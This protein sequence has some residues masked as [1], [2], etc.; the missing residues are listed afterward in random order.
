MKQLSDEEL[1]TQSRQSGIAAASDPFLNEL[2]SRHQRRVSLWCLRYAGNRED[3]ADLA[4]EILAR[5]WRNL[6]SYQGN[7]KFTTWL[8][9]V[10]RNH[11]LNHVKAKSH[12]P[13]LL[14]EIID[15]ADTRGTSMEEGLAREE[16]VRLAQRWIADALDETERKVVR[17]HFADGMPVE[18]I[19]RL[20]GLQNPSGAKAH[21]VSA[22]RKLQESARRWKARYESARKH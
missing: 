2:F 12:E 10:C 4:Q 18:A 21:L 9:M 13:D 15:I 20:L 5:V 3:A 17:L 7:S 16:Q 19:T 1:I 8:Y 22:R 14:K 11:C 6:D